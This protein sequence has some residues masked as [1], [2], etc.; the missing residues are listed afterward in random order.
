MCLENNT[1]YFVQT[2]FVNEKWQYLKIKNLFI[3]CGEKIFSYLN[4][5]LAVMLHNAID[6]SEAPLTNCVESGEKTA[7]CTVFTSLWENTWTTFKTKLLHLIPQL[8]FFNL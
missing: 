4:K 8:N 1:Q 7:T 5:H 3:K 2:C 6:P